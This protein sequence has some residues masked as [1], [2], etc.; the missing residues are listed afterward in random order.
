M[1]S[2]IF[3][4]NGLKCMTST[5]FIDKKKVILVLLT[6]SLIQV[7]RCVKGVTKTSDKCSKTERWRG[8]IKI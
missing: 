4:I 6:M 8:E 7:R 1:P 5:M 3:D 2:V